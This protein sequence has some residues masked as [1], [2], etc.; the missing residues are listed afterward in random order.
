V[1]HV[2]IAGRTVTFDS[3]NVIPNAPHV[4][5]D[6][7]APAAGGG[8]GVGPQG[9]PGPPGPKGDTGEAGLSAYGELVANFGYTGT[10]QDF[11]ESLRGPA[12][13]TGAQGIQGQ[14]GET[15]PAGADGRD[16]APGQQGIPGPPGADGAAGIDGLD[17]LSAY[18]VA[19]VN[20]FSGTEAQ[21]LAS[22]VGPQGIPGNDG[23][24]GAPGAVGPAGPA[25]PAGLGTSIVKTTNESRT[26]STT[27]SADSALQAVLGVGVRYVKCIVFLQTANATMDYRYASAFTGGTAAVIAAYRRHTNAGATAG[28]DNENTLALTTQIPSTAVA[29][30]TSGIAKVEIEMLLDVTVSGTWQF[31]WCQNTSDAGALTVLRGSNIY[32]A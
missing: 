22:L 32:I 27:L 24:D 20:G 25:G 13:Q 30:T 31:Q 4:Y 11:L 8:G 26:L 21:W 7:G 28:T 29:A 16:G 14:P 6:V 18:Q 1:T 19:V 12:G 9:P 3:S 5:P 10:F 23:A 2:S 15:G 17:G